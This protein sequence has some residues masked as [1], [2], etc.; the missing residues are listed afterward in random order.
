MKMR[1]CA[2]STG[3]VNFPAKV[4]ELL[5]VTVSWSTHAEVAA[6]QVWT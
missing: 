6:S 1:R 2:V 4:V 5:F 3:A